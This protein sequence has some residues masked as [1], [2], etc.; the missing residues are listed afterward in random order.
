MQKDITV[1]SETCFS[2]ERRN[3]T[4]Y[5]SLQQPLLGDDYG[6]NVC[7]FTTAFRIFCKE[8]LF[9]MFV[10]LQ[11]PW[12]NKHESFHTYSS[13][14]VPCWKVSNSNGLSPTPPPP[15][16]LSKTLHGLSL[17]DQEKQK[18]TFAR[19]ISWWETNSR[20]FWMSLEKCNSQAGKTLLIASVQEAGR[21]LSG[22]RNW[23]GAKPSAQGCPLGRKAVCFKSRLFLS[24]LSF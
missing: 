16:L 20:L 9:T 6:G 3:I 8:K 2:F 13:A 1:P 12:L 5:L 21:L 10:I 24:K 4:S 14:L 7:L 22:R 18:Y 11:F 19:C 17:W 23:T 15:A